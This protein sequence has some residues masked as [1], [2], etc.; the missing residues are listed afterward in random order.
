MELNKE[1]NYN[2]KSFTIDYRINRLDVRENVEVET[3]NKPWISWGNVNNDYP[4]FLLQVKES[5]P[6]LSVAIDS[7]VNMSIGDGVELEGLGNVMVNKYETLTEL[8]YKLIYDFWIFGGFA[9]E[10]IPN[11]D[12]TGIESIYHLPFQNIRVGKK[13]FDDHQRE[14]DWY[15]YSEFWQLPVQNKKI[16]KFHTLD[17]ERRGE[18]RQIYYWTNYSPSDN[19]HYPITPYQ[20][21]INAAVIEAEVFDWHKR[22]LATS[23]MPNLFVSLVGSPTPEE[24]ELVYEELL[25]S[26][27]G[28]NGQKIMLAFS[29]TPEGKPEITPIQNNANDNFYT[30]VLQMCVQSILTSNQVSSPLL[31]GISSFSSNPFSQNADEL[32]VATKHM[33]AMVIEPALKK[34]NMS[35]QNV[36]SIKFNRPVKIVNKLVVPNFSA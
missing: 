12:H 18:A 15:Y 22:N 14:Q 4:Q 29:D 5:S 20:S 23:L 13:D 33:L 16:T 36:L 19:R 6:V 35:L 30:E 34:V 11:R 9:L 32:V 8:Y 7:K 26:Y 24:K 21:G 17:L 31:L 28:K 25:R 1:P 27:Q 2:F 3:K 10:C